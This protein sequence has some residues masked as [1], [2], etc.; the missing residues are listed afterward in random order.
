MTVE[1]VVLQ[2]SLGEEDVAVLD[3]I[4]YPSGIVPVPP[5]ITKIQRH[6]NAVTKHA[7]TL[8]DQTDQLRIGHEVIEEDLHLDRAES[9]FERH[10]ELPTD[11]AHQRLHG[12]AL[13]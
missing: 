1:I 3:A 2:G 11:L 6:L 9:G 10:P 12:T 5:A 7:A 4:E 8:L 13:G